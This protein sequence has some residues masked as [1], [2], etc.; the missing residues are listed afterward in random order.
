MSLSICQLTTG[1]FSDPL[2][3]Y[4]F[5]LDEDISVKERISFTRFAWILT[6][7]ND[8][9]KKLHGTSCCLLL[10]ISLAPSRIDFDHKTSESPKL[11]Q[12]HK[13]DSL[14][15]M[16]LTPYNRTARLSSFTPVITFVHRVR[17]LLM[18]AKP[19]ATFCCRDREE[20]SQ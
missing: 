3:N 4:G 13:L 9:I 15:L 12:T 20:I 14:Q 7:Q 16:A 8:S 18:S 2:R 17:S 5:C 11:Q 10:F 6:Y 1:F 19:K